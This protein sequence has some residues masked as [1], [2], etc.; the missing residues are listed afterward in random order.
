VVDSIIAPMYGI[1][2]FIGFITH[3]VGVF[4]SLNGFGRKT[5]AYALDESVKKNN[6]IIDEIIIV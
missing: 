3:N 1:F 2:L 4:F 5:A 6:T